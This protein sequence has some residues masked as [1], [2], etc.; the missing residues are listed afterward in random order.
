MSLEESTSRVW[1]VT[2]C[3]TGMGRALAEAIIHR[4][5]RLIATARNVS[6]LADLVAA[7]PDRCVAYALDVTVGTQ[8]QTI[9]EEAINHW[10]HVDV[11]VNNA[12]VG[13]LGALEETSYEQMTQNFATNFYGPISIM[14]AF[15]PHFRARKSGHFINISAAAAVSNYPGFSIY[16][17]SKAA[18]AAASESL[19]Q[20]VSGLGIGV[21]LIEPG[22]FRTDFASRS[23]H[24]VEATIDD[25]ASTVGKFR[26]LLGKIQG[27]QPGDP[28]KAANVMVDMVHAGKAP[29]RLP[30][31]KYLINKVKMKSASTLRELSEWEAIGAATEF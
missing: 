14:Q 11:V 7:A 23:L 5:D 20:E 25:Y 8:I 27:K 4:G 19:R 1:F 12:G 21:T 13:L 29:L 31:G 18:L 3:S 17:A 24:Q 28:A 6:A 22:P 30:L 9:V 16:G 15:L 2:G 26:D 10:G